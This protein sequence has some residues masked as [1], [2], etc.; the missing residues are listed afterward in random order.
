MSNLTQTLIKRNRKWIAE[1]DAENADL[2]K[3][4]KENLKKKAE[5]EQQIKDL[6]DAQ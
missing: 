3:Q 6:V 5:Y 2:Q 1:I 4:I